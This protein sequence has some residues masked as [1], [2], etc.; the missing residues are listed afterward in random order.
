ME[1]EIKLGRASCG[2]EVIIECLKEISRPL[3]NLQIICSLEVALRTRRVSSAFVETH[4][5]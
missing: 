1:R 2:K 5:L 4:F 3:R